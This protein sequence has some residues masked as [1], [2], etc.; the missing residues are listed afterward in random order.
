MRHFKWIYQLN[1][2]KYSTTQY[3]YINAIPMRTQCVRS[4]MWAIV[5]LWWLKSWCVC[6]LFFFP[7]MFAN[8]L[9]VCVCNACLAIK[10]LNTC[11]QCNLLF[12]AYGSQFYVRI[13][14]L[15]L[16]LAQSFAQFNS[17]W[18]IV[19]S[20]AFNQNTQTT[21]AQI[22]M[23]WNGDC[24]CKFTRIIHSQWLDDGAHKEHFYVV[25]FLLALMFMVY[26]FFLILIFLSFRTKFCM[27]RLCAVTSHLRWHQKYTIYIFVWV[28]WHFVC[29]FL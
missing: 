28:M 17:I 8:Y 11:N 18:L 16:S 15:S 7:T 13:L 5:V 10:N 23:E 20:I 29:E 14:S 4:E 25:D 26:I 9:H 19:E 22:P 27:H 12:D 1:P 21:A 6:V 24:K 2:I 3:I